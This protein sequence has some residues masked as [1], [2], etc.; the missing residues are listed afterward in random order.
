MI[1]VHQ[2][3]QTVTAESGGGCGGRGRGIRELFVL[4]FAV[5]PKWL[6]KIKSTVFV[7]LV[8]VPKN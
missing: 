2:L 7:F 1:L 6:G 3:Q 5:N 4:N 8:L